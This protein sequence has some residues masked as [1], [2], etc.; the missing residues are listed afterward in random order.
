MKTNINR[1]TIQT[2]LILGITGMHIG[3]LE[4]VGFRLPNQDP[5]GIARGNA[6]VAT[7]DNPSAIYYNPAGITQLE[8]HHVSL[9]AY[10]ISPGV[11]FT[12]TSGGTA[13]ADS[14]IQLVPQI[15]YVY[16]PE[17]SKFSYGFGVYAPYGLGIDYGSDTPFSTIAQEATLRYVTANP[18]VAYQVTPE[19]S[20]AAGITL[21]YSNVDLEQNIRGIPGDKF[22]IDGNDFDIGFNL[23]FLWQPHENWSFGLNYRSATKMSY[24]GDAEVEAMIPG[25]PTGS[26]EINDVELDFPM[27]IDIGV[28]YRPNEKWNLEFNLDWTDWDSVGTAVFEGTPLG[29]VAFPFNYESSFM[30]EFG[31]TRYLENDYFV[32]AGYIYSENS[33]PDQNF[34]PLNPDSNLHLGSVGY[35]HRGENINWTVGY[36]FAYSKRTVTNNVSTS[37]IGE[38]ANGKYKTL[39]HAVNFS[40]S[41]AF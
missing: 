32:S 34:S 29:D 27:F 11:D 25:L 7:A 18:V 5:Q 35:G 17:E 30:Y 22:G 39:N 31:A 6:F 26:A 8:G 10:L 38:T 21:N 23:G 14:G 15:H 9:G 4:A 3:Q 13:H 19:F 16:S 12:S 40:V 24:D 33:V 2:L 37:L 36:H 1:I 41:Y 28:S 20:V